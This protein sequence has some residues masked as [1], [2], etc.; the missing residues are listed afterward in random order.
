MNEDEFVRVNA[1]YNSEERA[2]VL[3]VEAKK[4]ITVVELQGSTK[5]LEQFEAS[6]PLNFKKRLFG[7]DAIIPPE[8]EIEMKVMNKA[9]FRWGTEIAIASGQTQAIAIP[10]KTSSDE[11]NVLTLVYQYPKLFGLL[12]GKYS[13][14]VR[15]GEQ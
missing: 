3:E 13:I 15:L 5:T 9:Q 6:M 11:P 1:T 14:Y 10:A 12:K 7:E 2:L 4:K 8:M